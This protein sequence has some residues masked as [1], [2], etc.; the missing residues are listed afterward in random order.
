MYQCEVGN[1]L[2]T[3]RAAAELATATSTIQEL[4]RLIVLKENQ[5]K[6]LLGQNPGP[7]DT[8][9][10]LLEEKIPLDVPAGLALR[11]PVVDRPARFACG[12]GAGTHCH[13]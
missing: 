7:I 3:S 12:T 4:E 10:T 11:D 8:K 9:L 5:I 6:L 2:Q 1:A 13:R